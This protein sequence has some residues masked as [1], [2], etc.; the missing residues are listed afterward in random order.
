[1]TYLG[2]AM[3]QALRK[4]SSN[5]SAWDGFVQVASYRQM[6][7]SPFSPSTECHGKQTKITKRSRN[8][9][10]SKQFWQTSDE[11]TYKKV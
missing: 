7:C 10:R 8:Y 1:M 9:N 2:H 6:L 11:G 3:K 5:K 4:E